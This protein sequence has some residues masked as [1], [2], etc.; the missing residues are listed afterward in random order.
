MARSPKYHFDPYTLTYRQ[1]RPNLGEKILRA[2]G[3]FSL[4][5]LMSLGI[6]ITMSY[7]FDSPEEARLKQ[8]VEEYRR[9]FEAMQDQLNRMEKT[10]HSLERRDQQIYRSIFEAEPLSP[11]VRNAGYGGVERTADLKGFEY[12]GLVKRTRSQLKSLSKE[13]YVL[14]ESYDEI[15]KLASKKQELL[16]AIPSIQP[17]KNKE[18]TRI[19]SGYGNRIHPIYKTVQFHEGVDFTTAI[20]APVYATGK[21]K[22]IRKN[23]SKR[24]YGNQLMIDHGYGY[25]T[26]Y[27]HLAEF[28]VKAGETVQRG[29]L[30]GTIGNSGLSTGPHLHYEI[31]KNGKPVNPINY[32]HNE[33]SPQEY[34]KVVKLANQANQSLD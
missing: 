7:Y 1:Y 15:T 5:L 17:I 27:A 16:S 33:L 18:L 23:Y 32:F 28:K 10:V 26:R 20:G 24:G 31:R 12:E 4:S 6:Y 29:E 13:L 34:Q 14:S 11:A 25:K 9:K 21:G 22:V 3:I 30:I 2:F 19:A 8:E